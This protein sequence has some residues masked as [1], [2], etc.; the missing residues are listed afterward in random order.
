MA[1]PGSRATTPSVAMA[2]SSQLILSG[3]LIGCRPKNGPYLLARSHRPTSQTTPKR[4][5]KQLLQHIWS[6]RLLLHVTYE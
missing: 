5:G 3:T 1:R 2:A 4:Q 6:R